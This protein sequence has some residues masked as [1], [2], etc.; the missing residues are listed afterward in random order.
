MRLP[1]GRANSHVFGL[2]TYAITGAL[3]TQQTAT[4]ASI[5][6]YVDEQWTDEGRTWPRPVIEASDP[7]VVVAQSESAAAAAAAAANRAIRILSPKPTRGAIKA[8]QPQIE[9]DGLVDWPSRVLNVDVDG[10]PARLAPDGH[11]SA[12]VNLKNGLN[13]VDVI[14]TTEDPRLLRRTLELVYQG[15]INALQGQ[16]KRYAVIIANQDYGPSTGLPSLDTPLADARAIADEL[17]S[18]YGFTTELDTPD[19]RKLPLFLKDPSKNDILF[20]LEDLAK[21]IGPKDAVLIY[22]AGH[23]VYEKITGTAYW[24]P[25]DARVG[26]ASSFLSAD[27]ISDAIK[28]MQAG[29]VLLISDSCYSGDL[30]RGGP[31]VD[32]KISDAERNQALLRLQARRSR[33]LMT[34]GNNEP[35]EDLGGGGHSI[36]AKALLNGL[37]NEPHDAFSAR[38]LFQDFILEQVTANA[39]QEPQF[40]PLQKVGHEGGDFVFV[41]SKARAAGN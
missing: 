7:N 38:E 31:Q 25:S 41:R 28:R 11:F 22:Y 2:F 27:D 34:S 10:L 30:M 5:A 8:E 18:Q 23:G 24:V 12:T 37:E 40:R 20:R 16:G 14:A 39:D 15:D 9:I 17:T 21:N 1:R 35:V 6:R 3:A 26:Y 36:F 32:E 4:P 33:I 19:G 29:N 13:T